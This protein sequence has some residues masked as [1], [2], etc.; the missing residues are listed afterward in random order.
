MEQLAANSPFNILYSNMQQG[1]LHLW[2][3]S[4]RYLLAALTPQRECQGQCGVWGSQNQ[5]L[6]LFRTMIYT[7]PIEALS[8]MDFDVREPCC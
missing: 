3:M 2:Q 6:T 4:E 1:D 5:S 7:G 8:K